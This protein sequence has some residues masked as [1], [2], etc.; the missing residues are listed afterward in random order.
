VS[1]LW[2]RLW[3]RLRLGRGSAIMSHDPDSHRRLQLVV[4]GVHRPAGTLVRLDIQGVGRL[5]NRGYP[6]TG[7]IGEGDPREAAGHTTALPIGVASQDT[8]VPAHSVP[9]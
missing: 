3:L 4:H 5:Q 9:V 1:L 6:I 7:R 2:L 8:Q